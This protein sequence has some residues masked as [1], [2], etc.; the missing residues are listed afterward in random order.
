ML[1]EIISAVRVSTGRAQETPSDEGG[2]TCS[3]AARYP[4]ARAAAENGARGS[5]TVPT[6]FGGTSRCL[7]IK[8]AKEMQDRTLETAKHCWKK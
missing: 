2:Q 4:V 8:S 1:M 7:G 5:R 6:K 3:P